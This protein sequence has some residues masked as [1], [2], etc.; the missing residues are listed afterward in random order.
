MEE[1]GEG[2]LPSRWTGA[3]CRTNAFDIVVHFHNRR[4]RDGTMSVTASFSVAP[5]NLTPWNPFP[6]NAKAKMRL[7][8]EG[9]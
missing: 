1:K 8:R 3:K 7:A 2:P 5:G 4:F 6:A 9:V